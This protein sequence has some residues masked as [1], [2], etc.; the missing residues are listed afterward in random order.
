MLIL[1][2]L[3]IAN[4]LLLMANLT[5]LIVRLDSAPY[6]E[7]PPLPRR[8]PDNCCCLHANTRSGIQFHPHGQMTLYDFSMIASGL[9]REN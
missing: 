9:G 7:E 5:A 4:A 3:L 2:G 1:V 8:L 6:P